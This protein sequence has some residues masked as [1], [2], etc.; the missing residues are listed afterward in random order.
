MNSSLILDTCSDVE[1]SVYKLAA[2]QR[3]WGS[4]VQPLKKPTDKNAVYPYSAIN[5]HFRVGNANLVPNSQQLVDGTV[6]LKGSYCL[7]EG[8]IFLKISAPH[9]LMDDLAT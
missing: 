5:F 8:Q 2:L 7:G 1:T 9:A 6:T 3:E 4:S